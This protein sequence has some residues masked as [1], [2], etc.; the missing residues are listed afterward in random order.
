MRDR[1]N[2]RNC[3]V[4][5]NVIVRKRKRKKLCYTHKC[6][7]VEGKIEQVNENFIYNHLETPCFLNS[8]CYLK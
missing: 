3:F 1:D 4:L 6:Y 5:G 2:Q 8:S 7:F